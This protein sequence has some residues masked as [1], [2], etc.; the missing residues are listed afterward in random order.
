[1]LAR[2]RAIDPFR[3]DL[4]L[5]AV[6]VV[7]ALV[8]LVVLVPDGARYDHWAVA[9]IVALGVAVAIRRRWPLVSTLIAMPLLIGF[10]LLGTD[11]GDH[12]VSPFFMLLFLL[13]SM[14]RNVEGRALYVGLAYA[15]VCALISQ[16]TDS[17]D[18]KNLQQQDTGLPLMTKPQ[19]NGHW[20]SRRHGNRHHHAEQAMANCPR[21]TWSGRLFPKAA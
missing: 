21:P 15:V 18:A 4:L 11:Y 19:R 12:M 17:Y 1:M 14:G 9:L 6:F 16:A 8:E 20:R 5:A 13:Y 7:E 2:M 10:N 3:A